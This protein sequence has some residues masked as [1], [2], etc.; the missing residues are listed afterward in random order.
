MERGR[1]KERPI[2]GGEGDSERKNAEPRVSFDDEPRLE[3]KLYRGGEENRRGD[4]NACS[5]YPLMVFYNEPLG[6]RRGGGIPSPITS[7]DPFEADAA[8]K[9]KLDFERGGSCRWRERGSLTSSPP[10][11]AKTYA[12]GGRIRGRLR[13]LQKE[14]ILLKEAPFRLTKIFIIEESLSQKT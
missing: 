8:R 6:T 10:G 13:H 11:E 14:K 5:V 7:R 1:Q 2:G 4:S 9:K 3:G 12:H